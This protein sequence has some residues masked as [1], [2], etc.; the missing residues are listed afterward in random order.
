MPAKSARSPRGEAVARAL[1][2]VELPPA[3]KFGPRVKY[4]LNVNAASLAAFEEAR[5][6]SR[7]TAATQI[8]KVHKYESATQDG[9]GAGMYKTWL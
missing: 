7:M 1:V 9:Y 3:S 4:Q 6:G 5:R 2:S 8:G